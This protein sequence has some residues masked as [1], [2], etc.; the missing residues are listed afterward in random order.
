MDISTWTLC[1]IFV[2]RMWNTSYYMDRWP[3]ITIVT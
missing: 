3:R 2:Y 1:N